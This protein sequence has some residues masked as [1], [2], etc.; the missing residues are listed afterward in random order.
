MNKIVFISLYDPICVGVRTLISILKKRTNITIYNILLKKDTSNNPVFKLNPTKTYSFFHLG[1][2]RNSITEANPITFKEKTIL[3]NFLVKIKPDL[4]CLSTRS[5]ALIISQELCTDIKKFLPGT[6]LIAGGWGP[7]LEPEKFLEFCDYVVFGEGEKPIV[8]ISKYIEKDKSHI[9]NIVYKNLDNVI[10]ANPVYPPLTNKELNLLPFPDYGSDNEYLIDDNK[11]LNGKENLNF[12][13]YNC[14]TGRGCLLSCSY[15]MSHMYIQLYLKYGFKC[16]KHRL[17]NVENII[18]ELSIAKK[19]GSLF[20]RFLDEVFPFDKKWIENFLREYK[21]K[22]N[23]P[24]M[25]FIRPEFHNKDTIVQLQ[26]CGL[27][28]SIVGIQSGSN[29]ILV[30]IYNRNLSSE[31]NIELAWL[32]KKL[33]LNFAYHMINNNPFEKIDDLNKTLLMCYHLPYAPIDINRLVVFPNSHL[34]K[35]INNKK[36]TQ[37]PLYIHDWYSLLYSMAL[38]NNFYRKISKIIYKFRIAKKNPYILQIFFI[39]FLIKEYWQRLRGV[40]K[41]N[42]KQ[43]SFIRNFYNRIKG[44]L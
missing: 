42:S 16:P 2:L 27:K 5:F 10:I 15:C 1:I 44:K 30:D 7:T 4:I 17:R 35:M 22:I 34:E 3:Y 40:N 18:K 36:T 39:P 11:L 8:D 13:I 32:F 37:L 31:S 20:I 25:A 41:Y 6:Q 12:K 38:Q 14:Y 9:K 23:L 33:K 21:Q 24:F 26:E 29:R 43:I 28:V 19:R